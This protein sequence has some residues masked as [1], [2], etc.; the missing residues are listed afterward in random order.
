MRISDWSS[1]VCSSDLPFAGWFGGTCLSGPFSLCPIRTPAMAVWR[2]RRLSVFHH[3][4]LR[5]PAQRAALFH[6]AVR[7]APLPASVSAVPDP[8]V[9][10]RAAQRRDNRL[11]RSQQLAHP[12]RRRLFYHS[13]LAY[14]TAHSQRVVPDIRVDFLQPH[15]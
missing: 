8:D 9:A 2:L 13:V 3:Q 11:S 14:V 12:P 6:W 1:D 4:R 15:L 5:H 7:P 10:F